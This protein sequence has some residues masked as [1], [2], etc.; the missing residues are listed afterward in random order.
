[1][2]VTSR[3]AVKALALGGEEP[4]RQ[5]RHLDP[6]GRPSAARTGALAS[7]PLRLNRRCDPIADGAPVASC[8]CSALSAERRC[9]RR[10]VSLARVTRVSRV[11]RGSARS[12]RACGVVMRRPLTTMAPCGS[13][14]EALQPDPAGAAGD[15]HRDHADRVR[16]VRQRAAHP[17][18]QAVRGACRF[19]RADRGRRPD[20]LAPAG[21]RGPVPGPSSP[22]RTA[23]SARPARP[24]SSSST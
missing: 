12:A 8:V 20:I 16:A 22:S 18:R 3:I 21:H 5:P 4:L 23:S 6:A 17:A 7:G 24:T 10:H 11:L 1:M 19:D 14:P 15:P 9:G 2:K 13:G